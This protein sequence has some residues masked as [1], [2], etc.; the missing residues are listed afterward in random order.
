M[1]SIS[2]V[3]NLTDNSVMLILWVITVIALIGAII[4]GGRYGR[5]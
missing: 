1:A 5:K 2:Q 4:I 3:L